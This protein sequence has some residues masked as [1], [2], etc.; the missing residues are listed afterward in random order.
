MHTFGH[1]FTYGNATRNYDSIDRLI[2]FVNKF[3]YI[4]GIEFIYS[5]PS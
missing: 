2:Y 4:F 5:T 1:D 3:R